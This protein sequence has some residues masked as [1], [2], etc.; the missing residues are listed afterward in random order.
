V[1]FCS[2]PINGCMVANSALPFLCQSKPIH[3]SHYSTK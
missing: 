2:P 1:G 3:E